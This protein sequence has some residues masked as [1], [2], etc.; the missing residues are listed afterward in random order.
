MDAYAV[1]TS[2]CVLKTCSVFMRTMNSYEEQK[3]VL[4][5]ILR[6]TSKV[7]SARREKRAVYPC[8]M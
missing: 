4:L 5:Y 3:Q 7:D 6:S 8:Q 1:A 2:K